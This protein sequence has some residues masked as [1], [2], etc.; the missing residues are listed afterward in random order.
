MIRRP[1][2][3]VGLLAAAWALFAGLL[4]TA[5]A[6]DLL[7]GRSAIQSAREHASPSELIEGR[8]LADLRAAHRRLAAGSGR[9]GHPVLLPLRAMPF[10]G[11]QLR[12]LRAQARAGATVADAG[13]VA[14]VEARHALDRHEDGLTPKSV[15]ARQLAGVADDTGRRVGSLGLG[16]SRGLI[17]PIAD[18]RNEFAEKL[19]TLRTGLRQGAAGARAMATLLE[20]PR[21]YLVFAANNAEMRAG[22]GMFLSVGELEAEADRL[23]LQDMRSVTSVPVPPGSV[24][25]EGDL[26]D[27]W[28]WLAPNDEWRNLMLSPR[29]DAQAPL[30][31]EMWEAT[32]RPPV[33]G[34]LVL[35]PF[36]VQGLLRATGPV[37]ADGR[38]YSA[39]SVVQELLHGQYVRFAPEEGEDRREQ[40]GRI[41]RATFELLNAGRWSVAD[42][43]RGIL[44]AVRGRHLLAW[45]AHPREQEDW[46]VAGVDGSLR[47]E[48]LL[49][50]VLNRGGN[51]LDQFLEVS[52]EL[53]V[54]QAGPDTFFTVRL[55][56]ANNT[57]G[58]EPEYIAGPSPGSGLEEGVYAG[59]VAVSLPGAAEDG[60][61]DGVPELAV[62]GADGP[63]RVVGAPLQLRRGE[64]RT[65][66][67]RFGLPS[68]EGQM[69]VEPSARAP[70]VRW[71]SGRLQWADDSPRVVSWE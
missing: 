55:T 6:F 63:S 39:D 68:R 44:P 31:A 22:S 54:T 49:V 50:A 70:A 71:R 16:P 47:P 35:D 7:A 38:W 14:V 57:P 1:R 62:A 43:A 2:V 27:R 51:K 28:G 20:G 24:P 53:D 3:V 13:A 45:S 25:L 15:L 42:L 18:A 11:R 30:A 67:V 60:R 56:L 37:E 41:A 59:I 36:A 26:R 32:G 40:L 4:L 48:S 21:R 29:F 65:V 9:I 33:D 17:R 34:V 5:A 8:P 46:A 52:S 66:V 10:V 58:G 12:S 23:R 69:T 61:I 64:Q 19:A